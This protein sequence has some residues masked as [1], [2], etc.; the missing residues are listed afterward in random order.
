[1]KGQKFKKIKKNLG[2]KKC[3]IVT[4]AIYLYINLIAMVI[5][6]ALICLENIYKNKDFRKF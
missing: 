1:M 6:S 2:V 4:L 5:I 3:K